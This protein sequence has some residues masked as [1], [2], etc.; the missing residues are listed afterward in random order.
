MRAF[1]G[2]ANYYKV[3]IDKFATTA[4]SL[5]TLTGK[6]FFLCTPK[7]QKTFESLK[8][9]F[10]SALILAQFDPEKETRLEAD[11]FGYTAGGAL[12]QKGISDGI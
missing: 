8:K 1:L 11:S 12:L 6:H 4:T 9:S 10:I 5:I 7:A 3:F 2:F